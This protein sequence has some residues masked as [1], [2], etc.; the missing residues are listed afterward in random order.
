[1]AILKII[2]KYLFNLNNLNLFNNFRI[3]FFD[4]E[5]FGFTSQYLEVL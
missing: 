5:L 3:F 2:N 1:M 4:E